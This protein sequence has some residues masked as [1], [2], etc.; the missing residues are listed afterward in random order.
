MDYSVRF[1]HWRRLDSLTIGELVWMMRNIDPR[2]VDELPEWADS[3]VDDE[4]QMLIAAAHAGTIAISS[5]SGD[6]RPCLHTQVIRNERLCGWLRGKG[7]NRVA[8]GLSTLQ[9]QT[10]GVTANLPLSRHTAQ[11]RAILAEIRRQGFDPRA[12]PQAEPGKPGVKASV[13]GA[14]GNV[15]LWAGTT[16]FSKAWDRLRASSEIA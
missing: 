4:I 16:V 13:K 11:E 10:S 2:L 9:P 5:L 14:L 7:W 1:E 12:L 8:D 6:T 15:G 3:D